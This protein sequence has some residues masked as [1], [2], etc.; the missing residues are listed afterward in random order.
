MTPHRIEIACSPERLAR[1]E[2]NRRRLEACGRFAHTDRVPVLLS[3]SQRYLFWARGARIADYYENPRTQ[4]EQQLLNQ[5]WIIEHLV[6]DRVVDETSVTVAPGFDTVRGGYFATRFRLDIDGSAMAIPI[7]EKAED[8]AALEVPEVTANLYGTKIAWYHAMKELA[9]EYEVTLNGRPLEIKV[10][11]LGVGGP[12]PDAYALASANILTWM[13]ESPHLVHQLMD[14]VTTA[15]INYERYARDLTGRPHR[16]LGMGA[17]AA[18]M[19]SP[20]MF[21]EFVLPYYIRCYEAFP[22]TRGLHMCGRINHLIP[23]LADEL[24]VTHLNGFGFVTDPHLLAQWMGGRVVMGGGISP[25]LLVEGDQHKIKAECFR[26]LEILSP[27]GGYIL[28]DGN[29][30]APGTSL[31]S[32]TAMAEAAREYAGR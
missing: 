15:F 6:D 19:L 11:V 29:G 14:K 21:R 12:F 31:G 4:L 13:Y 2:E 20:A 5:Q 28:Q 17:D 22:G 3:L 30:V 8:I 27:R 7:L 18:E 24:R 10:S 26:Y 1:N 32:M 16:N 9:T 25:A 23:I